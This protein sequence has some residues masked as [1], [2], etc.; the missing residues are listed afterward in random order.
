MKPLD[1][2]GLRDIRRNLTAAFVALGDRPT[3]LAAAGFQRELAIK[4]LAAEAQLAEAPRKGRETILDHIRLLR[5]HGDALAWG[6]LHPHAIRQF[7]KGGGR[8][9]SLS[10]QRAALDNALA[11]VDGFAS[12]GVLAL[13][14]DLTTHLQL[15][16]VIVADAPEAPT[17]IECKSKLPPDNSMLLGRRGRQA[18]KLQGTAQYLERGVAQLHGE[19]RVR[20]CFEATK[21]IVPRWEQVRTAVDLALAEGKG[22]IQQIERGAVLWVRVGDEAPPPETA[23]VCADFR[24]LIIGAHVRFLDDDSPLMPPPLAWPLSELARWHLMEMDLGVVMILDLAR[25]SELAAERGR[26]IN[27]LDPLALEVVSEGLPYV[28]SERFVG[29]CLYNF[30]PIDAQVEMLLEFVD[31]VARQGIVQGRSDASPPTPV[32]APHRV[33]RVESEADIVRLAQRDVNGRDSVMISAE[34]WSKIA[35]G[36]RPRLLFWETGS[37]DTED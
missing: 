12:D 34:L 19:T 4:L 37:R 13:V 25:F 36:K 20:L 11:I 28:A 27:I 6:Q 24:D 16:D 10:S 7:R 17:I 5:A 18:A 14:T 29:E 23:A 2:E 8:P 30:H 21:P 1:T 33:H 32:G 26:T 3:P 22:S 31:H 15:G 9:H 35:P